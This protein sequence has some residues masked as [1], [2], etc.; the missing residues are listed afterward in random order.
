MGDLVGRLQKSAT[1]CEFTARSVLL[2]DAADEIERL[3]EAMKGA[4]I[5]ANT[6]GLLLQANE[7]EIEKLRSQLVMA[8]DALREF[9]EA[10]KHQDCE[11][12]QDAMVRAYSIADAHL[13]LSDDQGTSK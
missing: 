3:R 7:A 1:A 10:Y 4:T 2:R 12:Y 6:S 11:C 5:I 9:V 8:Q 13:S